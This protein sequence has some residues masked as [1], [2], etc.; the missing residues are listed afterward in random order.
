MPLRKSA[1]PHDFARSGKGRAQM[2]DV[3]AQAGVSISTVSHILN[4]TREVAEPTRKRV[5]QAMEDLNYYKNA[6]GRRLKRGRSDSF[7]LII[8]DILNPFFAELIKGYEDVVIG[9]SCDVLLVSTNY[10]HER[11]KMAVRRMIEN[12]VQGVAIMTSQLDSHL[13]DDLVE[14]GI[15]VVRLDSGSTRRGLS[16]ICVEYLCG[17]REAAAHLKALGHRDIAMISGP[18]SRVSAVRYQNA[19]LTALNEA[20]LPPVRVREG[21]NTIDGGASGVRNLLAEPAPF[22]TAIL[23]GNDL[24]ALGAVSSLAEAGLRVPDDVS[25]I[26]A[27][28]ISYASYAVPALTT[29]RMPR[30]ELGARAYT[31]LARCLKSKR[32]TGFQDSVETHLVAR[33]STG[34][35]RKRP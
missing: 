33:R 3:A 21:S 4:N 26:G 17:A 11:S 24:S 34:P 5:L 1:S 22:P 23:F 16:D 30:E 32:M 20:G 29:V 27:D 35:A 2:K 10:D 28:D 7:G 12:S 15:P 19:L 31:V 13:V 25:I 8:S 14:A 9:N 6:F 18:K